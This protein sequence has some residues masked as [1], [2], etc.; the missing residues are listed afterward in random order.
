MRIQDRA[1]ISM[2][3]RVIRLYSDLNSLKIKGLGDVLLR[4]YI[5]RVG[6]PRYEPAYY[7]RFKFAVS[8][9][10]WTSIRQQNER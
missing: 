10:G 9:P 5:Q 1:N 7:F 8:Q 4:F 6:V 3:T 2:R